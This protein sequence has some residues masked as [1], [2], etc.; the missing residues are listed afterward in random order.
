[1]TISD[2][3][4]PALQQRYSLLC[5]ALQA[6]P[7]ADDPQPAL[8]TV[9]KLDELIHR[10]LLELAR[11]GSPDDFADIYLGFA[12]ELARFREF[13]ADPRL[14]TK[15][16]VA[17]GGP[18]SAGKSSLIN[19][20]IGKKLLVVEVDPTTALPTYVLAGETDAIHALNL[21]RLR[22]PLADEELASLTHDEPHRY[23]SQVS[24]ALSAAF[25]TRVDF[26]WANLAFIDTPGYSG[27]AIAGDRTDADVAAAQLSGAHAIVWVVSIKQGNLT[28]ADLAFL[29]RLDANIPRIVVASHADQLSDT[30]RAAVIQRI[31][32]TLAAHNLAVLGVFPVS[33]RPRQ[34]ELLD[35]VRTQLDVW[36]QM[37]RQ[38]RFAHRF[39]ALFTQY[40]RGIERDTRAA[41]WQR[42]RI[43]R[44]AT[45]AEDQVIDA[46]NELKDNIDIRLESLKTVECQLQKLSSRFFSEL[47]RAGDAVGIPL[48]EP[49]ELELLEPGRN[50]LLER[51]VSLRDQEGRDE[52]S[53]KMA[54]IPLRKL[55]SVSEDKETLVDNL[56][57]MFTKSAVTAELLTERHPIFTQTEYCRYHYALLLVAVIQ[58]LPIINNRQ[59]FLIVMLLDAIGV[60]DIRCSLYETARSLSVA[61]LKDAVNQIKETCHSHDLML[62][63]LILLSLGE[64]INDETECLIAEYAAIL[65]INAEELR[66]FANQTV[67][68]QHWM[69]GGDFTVDFKNLVNPFWHSLLEGCRRCLVPDAISAA[70]N[71]SL[72]AQ[73]IVGKIYLYG[74]YG[75]EQDTGKALEWFKKAAKQKSVTA[76]MFLGWIYL[77]GIGVAQDYEAARSWFCK[78]AKQN[79]AF[80]QYELARIY[81][82][83]LG[84]S[85]SIDKA[86]NLFSESANH[87]YFKAQNKLSSIYENGELGTSKNSSQA[88]TVLRSAAEQGNPYAQKRLGI[89]Y[90]MGTMGLEKKPE[91]GF[92]YILKSAES[93]DAEGQYILGNMYSKG[94]GVKKNEEKGLAWIKKSAMQGHK[95]AQEYL[96]DYDERD[97]AA[98]RFLE[99]KRELEAKTKDN[100]SGM[101][102]YFENRKYIKDDIR[103][104][105]DSDLGRPVRKKIFGIW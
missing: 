71:G 50:D 89:A 24:R 34:A 17:F 98:K 90:A 48:P 80:S 78:A 72:G 15:T 2:L 46:A 73:N 63:S 37:P 101:K 11:L 97:E 5:R 61:T 79:D 42:H 96:Q 82:Q 84:V 99:F 12:R 28:E 102:S 35:L 67:I 86:L 31:A 105:R 14:A 47:M 103:Y 95:P 22:I 57:E 52:P 49:H 40:Q 88:L 81:E 104:V 64:P 93:G 3:D 44:I 51:L 59:I 87:G 62:D 56:S 60:G 13:C 19:A 43:N 94:V 54:L 23:G 100:D 58:S 25:I 21:H 20:L 27:R 8:E 55:R 18:F 70:K 45:L 10:E 38:H 65:G 39:K 76:Q 4:H 36:N 30:D 75:V 7:A 16:I 68:V 33:A 26:P 41:R 1:M 6:T 74:L 83:G 29:A 85:V 69:C 32:D 53:Y 91:M 9:G 77:K 92:D 66:D